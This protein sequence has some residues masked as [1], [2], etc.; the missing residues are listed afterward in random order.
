M[1]PP[2][3]HKSPLGVLFIIAGVVLFLVVAGEFLVKLALALMAL[4]LIAYGVQLHTG[5]S[6][7]MF[8]WLKN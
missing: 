7:N 3:H 8:F 4:W 5:R 6:V 2:V 1:Y